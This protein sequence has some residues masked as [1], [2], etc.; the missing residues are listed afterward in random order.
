M[1][2]IYLVT[3]NWLAFNQEATATRPDDLKIGIASNTINFTNSVTVKPNPYRLSI[4][5][6]LSFTQEA[7]NTNLYLRVSNALDFRHELAKVKIAEAFNYIQF[8]D[9]ARTVLYESVRSELSLTQSIQMNRGLKNRLSF[10]QA[11]SFI[12]KRVLN[13]EQ[14]LQLRQSVTIYKDNDP[15]FTLGDYL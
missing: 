1:A 11:V 4:T 9:F 13:V 14:E 2:Q 15:N 3:G 5:Q 6:L 10:T 7:R 8:R 12:I